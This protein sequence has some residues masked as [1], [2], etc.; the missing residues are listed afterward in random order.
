MGLDMYLSKAKRIDG[1]SVDDLTNLN[2]YFG[3]CVRPDK[4]RDDTPKTWSGLDMRYVNLDLAEK[5]IT[6]YKK[7][8]YLFDVEKKYGY[9]SLFEQVGYWRKANQIH[10]WFVEYVQEN[11]D[12]C[13]SYEVSKEQLEELL[14]VCKQVLKG[15]KLVK[16][17]VVNGQRFENGKLENIYEDGEYI[18]NPSIAKKLLPCESGFF[19]GS[20]DYDQWYY[21]DVEQTVDI[22]E[23]VL[24]NTD[25]EHEIVMYRSSW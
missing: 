2:E 17:K 11:E 12:N 16:G 25:F 5:Y 7:R 18:E 4:Y 8:Y 3:Y 9:L 15:S 13:D 20:T 10:R 24:R 23:D 14:N 21:N 19:F 22:L 6:E 1:V